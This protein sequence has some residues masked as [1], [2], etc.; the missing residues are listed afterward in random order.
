MR[1]AGLPRFGLAVCLTEPG[2]VHRTIAGRL[3]HEMLFIY[4]MVQWYETGEGVFSEPKNAAIR[5]QC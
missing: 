5:P 3:E 1:K 4:A 2:F